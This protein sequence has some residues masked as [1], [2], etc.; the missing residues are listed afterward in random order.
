MASTE[1]VGISR[2]PAKAPS[3]KSV[4]EKR[5]DEKHSH[6]KDLEGKVD[7]T[8]VNHLNEKVLAVDLHIGDVFEDVRDDLLSYSYTISRGIRNELSV[9]PKLVRKCFGEPH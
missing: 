7:F 9:T 4:D 5:S 6:E 3:E 1:P 2:E 8:D